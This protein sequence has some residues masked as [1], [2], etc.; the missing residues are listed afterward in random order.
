MF[1]H[2]I[3]PIKFK[4]DVIKPLYKKGICSEDAIVC[5]TNRIY[6]ALHDNKST[7]RIFLDITRAFDA[8]DHIKRCGGLGI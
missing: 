6:K 2:G 3:F 4:I 5:Q 8:V 1:R 7:L